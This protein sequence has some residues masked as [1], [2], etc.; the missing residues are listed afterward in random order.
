MG[1]PEAPPAYTN[2]TIPETEYTQRPPVVG[3]EPVYFEDAAPRG[4]S[5]TIN[6]RLWTDG[7]RI[8][9]SKDAAEKFDAFKN[10]QNMHVV[11]LQRKGIGI[12]LF[13]AVNHINPV[14]TKFLTFRRYVPNQTGKFDIDK[15][16]YIYCQ[17][18]KK[19]H[20]GYNTYVFDFTPD[21]LSS[22]A[23]FQIVMFAHSTL[24]ICDYVYKGE[25]HRW[26]DESYRTKFKTYFQVKFG[27]KHSILRRGQPSLVDSWDGRTDKLDKEK[28]NPYLKSLFKMKLNP[29]ARLPKPEYYGERCTAILGEAE[30]YFKLGY[31]EVKID[32]LYNPDPNVDY[33][34][35]LSMHQ[36]ALVLVCVA[37]VLKRQKDIEEDARR[38]SQ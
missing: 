19:Y 9:V 12:P 5:V 2:T 4:W 26:I 30:S 27:Y 25:V 7:F 35:V 16:F 14:T 22:K 17:V 38:S 33:E 37:T 24:P 32:D 20:V 31:G 6:N 29:K 8:F 28:T 18:R 11:D 36:D 3:D 13:K 10:N 23:N 1:K 34:S 21:S 15:D